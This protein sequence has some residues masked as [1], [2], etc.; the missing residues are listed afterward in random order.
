MTSIRTKFLLAIGLLAG[1]FSAFL[2][3]RTWIVTRQQAERLTIAQA[4]LAHQFDLAIRRYV[5]E[6]IRPSIEQR[7]NPDEFDPELMSTSFVARS[8]FEN[9]CQ[10]FHDYII[11]FSSDNPRNPANAAGPEELQLLQHFREHPQATKWVGPLVI[12]GNEYLVHCSPRRMETACQRCHGRPEEAPASL[13]R[14]YGDQAGFHRTRGDVIA[15]DMIGIPLAPIKAEASSEAITQLIALAVFGVLLL[16]ALLLVF[17][18]LIGRRLAAIAAHF[19]L[20]AEQPENA[21]IR[22]VPVTGDDEIG[23]LESSLNALVARGQRLHASLEHR[24]SERTASLEAEIAERKNAEQALKESE[25]R[26]DLAIQGAVLGLWDWNI[27]TG[28]QT[29]NR[30]WAEM[31]GYTLEEVQPHIHSWEQWL[32]PDDYPQVMRAL[33]AHFAHHTDYAPEFRSKSKSGEW[34]WI[35]SRGKVVEWTA[36]GNPVRMIGMHQDITHWKQT[37]AELARTRDAAEAANRAK[38]EF[39]A[40]MSH[41]IR[42]PMTAILG[43]IDL[44]SESCHKRCPEIQ[45]EL[46]DPMTVISQNAHHLLQV[47]DDVLD[48]SKIEAGKIVVEQM[49]C[50]PHTLIAEVA[51]LMQLHASAK[52]LTFTVEIQ[53]PLPESIQS[54]P[55]RLRQILL[56]IM[57]NAVKFTEQGKIG[58]VAWLDQTSP[59]SPLLQIEVSDTGIGMSA[60]MLD[61]LF[62]PFTQA[63]SSTRRQYGGTGLGLTISRRLAELLGGQI[64]VQSTLGQGS[65]FTVR[66][67]TGPLKGVRLLESTQASILPSHAPSSDQSESNAL[68]LEGCRTLLAEDGPDNQR[69]IACL[70]KK[71]G[72]EVAVAENGRVAVDL[73]LVSQAE[74]RPFH[75]ILMDM[76][77][78]V[79]DGYEAVRTLRTHG[80]TGPILALTAHAMAEDRQKCLDAGCND[81]LTKPVARAKLVEVVRASYRPGV[82]QATEKL[83]G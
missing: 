54:D 13:R 14:Q 9:V 77:M 6:R 11:K 50:S 21:P 81:Y 69:L 53:G 27:Q 82:R 10:R 29:V 35:Q 41:E 30:R 3:W 64:T 72:A 68:P 71:A 42:T 57:G 76:Q 47:I 4:E 23:I 65:R 49:I 80:W 25:E 19:K 83:D 45:A 62:S 51:S 33:H 58:L 63:D 38:S 15:L 60:E 73:A 24:V 1:V 39:L 28:H 66:V 43:Y 2:F 12:R 32:H 70:L 74:G 26:L 46:G 16:G 78:P 8:I 48:L 56:N 31:L 18:S 22:P 37:Q 55:T 7:V 61:R 40:N 34:I 79:M 44:L 5:G 67:P 17:R 75:V 36:T 20:A 59:A 52:G